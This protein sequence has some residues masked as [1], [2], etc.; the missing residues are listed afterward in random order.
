MHVPLSERIAVLNR[1][2]GAC[3]CVEVLRFAQDDKFVKRCGDKIAEAS[4]KNTSDEESNVISQ[5]FERR[6]LRELLLFEKIFEG[7]AGVERARGS[8]FGDRCLL[9]WLRV[10]C[11][12]C[13]LFHGGAKFVEGAG[14]LGVFGGDAFRDGLRTLKLSAGIEEAALFAAV[15]FELTLGTLAVGIE[16]GSEDGAAVGA[17]RAGDGADHARGARA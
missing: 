5:I 9:C 6:G 17:A 10:G 2:V 12:R 16:T 7:L 8:S 4:A 14:V 13:V 15:E 3:F 11:G 1:K